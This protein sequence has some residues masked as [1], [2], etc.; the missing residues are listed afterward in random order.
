MED[1]SWACTEMACASECPPGQ[2]MFY[3]GCGGGEDITPIAPGCYTPC[4]PGAGICP[5]SMS[6]TLTDINPCVCPEGDV[7][8]AACGA[9]QYLCL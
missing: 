3:P 2:E 5:D 9:G 1:G 8:C 6:C 7:C 4:E